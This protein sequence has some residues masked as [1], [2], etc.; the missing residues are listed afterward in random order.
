MA[1]YKRGSALLLVLLVLIGFSGLLIGVTQTIT[2]QKRAATDSAFA[3]Q[4]E[5]AARS[6]LE[7]GLYA[8]YRGALD[9]RG[10]F[11]SVP[12]TGKIY[13][14]A[15]FTRGYKVSS[16]GSPCGTYTQVA[17]EISRDCPYYE[18][19]VRRIVAT[20][21]IG[22]PIMRASELP[23]GQ[24]QSFDIFQSL[25]TSPTYA[26]LEFPATGSFDCLVGPRRNL[27]REACAFEVWCAQ[28]CQSV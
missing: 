2:T 27:G 1:H 7:E 17:S 23:L 28:T 12:T 13:T 8:F 15:P 22:D 14:F 24:V 21:S 18:V 26:H 6:G 20:D 16:D 19:S 4:A 11:G 10:E 5:R 9:A 3:V 25:S